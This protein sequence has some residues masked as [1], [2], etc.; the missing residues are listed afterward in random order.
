[1]IDF[2][3]ALDLFPLMAALLAALTC[4]LLGNFLVLRKISLMGDA[5]SHSVLPGLVIAFLITSTR[6]PMIMFIGAAAA[7]LATVALVEVVK[8]LGRV[9]S[10]AAMGVVFSIL[11]AFGVLLIEQAAARHVD[12]DADCV[13]YGQLETLVWFEAPLELGALLSFATIEALPRQVIVLFSILTL[14]L[15]FVV[16]FFKELR[17]TAFDPALATSLGINANMMHYGLMLFVAAATVAAFEAVGSILVIAMLVCPGATAR[18]WTDRLSH[19]IF[20]SLAF[21][22]GSAV[23]GYFGATTI[24]SWFDAG[25]VNAAGSM[26]VAAGGFLALSVFFAP[27]YGLVA[28][29]LR[30]KRLQ[31]D[32]AMDQLLAGLLRA[33]EKGA[34]W[35]DLCVLTR[36]SMGFDLG[37]AAIRAKRLGYVERQALELNL[38]ARGL[39]EAKAILR[40][41]R[42]WESYLVDDA[43]IRPDNVH[44]LA[45]QLEHIS[46]EPTVAKE[47]DPHGQPIYPRKSEDDT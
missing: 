37:R 8:K 20:V 46:V 12:L 32:S 33:R 18:L 43:G 15:A 11:F 45:E 19:Q 40:R 4:G 23:T 14:S 39:E 16:V 41:H 10:G 9:E 25:S 3:P 38:T 21:A 13:L 36:A 7:G 24:P 5:I 6:S 26:T 29:R 44:A 1:V 17:V 30:A 35:I 42:G 27:Q 22:T 47:L 31:R 2:I 28:K 34:H